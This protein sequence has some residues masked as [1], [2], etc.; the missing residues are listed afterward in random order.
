MSKIVDEK[1]HLFSTEIGNVLVTTQVVTE[2][3][4][5]DIIRL[6]AISQARQVQLITLGKGYDPNAI[7]GPRTLS[8]TYTNNRE[9]LLD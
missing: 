6:R 9:E 4:V 3:D 7:R 1:K 5:E 8:S 2:F